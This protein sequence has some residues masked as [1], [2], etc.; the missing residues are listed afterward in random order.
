MFAG[1]A[2][3]RSHAYTHVTYVE[4]IL[5]SHMLPRCVFLYTHIVEAT[6]RFL[7]FFDVV[8]LTRYFS[9]DI[10]LIR[11]TREMFLSL[12]FRQI[13]LFD[14]QQISPLIKKRIRY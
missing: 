5:F 13:Y 6:D 11:L 2:F 8:F 9:R 10:V 4:S 14:F 1:D 12:Y 3:T 7:G